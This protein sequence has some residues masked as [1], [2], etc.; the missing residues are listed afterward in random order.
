MKRLLASCAATIA[1]LLVPAAA[2]AQSGAV[3]R[4]NRAQQR[5]EIVDSQH[6]VRSYTTGARRAIRKLRAG[7]KVWFQ[8]RGGRITSLR[9]RGRARRIAFLAKVVSASNGKGLLL[10]L[11]DGSRLKLGTRRLGGRRGHRGRAHRSSVQIN[12]EGLDPGQV[13]LITETVDGA[14][15]VTI[16]IK[17]MPDASPTGDDQDVTGTITALAADG[18]TIQTA[19]GD[20][21]TF[22]ADPVLLEDFSVGDQVDV[23]Y[24]TDTAGDLVADDVEPLD[25]GGDS[26]DDLDAVGSVTAIAADS[27]TVQ[28]DGRGPMTFSADQELLDGVAVGDVVDVT[29]FQDT[30]GTLVADDIEP[31]DAGSGD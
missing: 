6:A 21:M 23:S 7:A 10:R 20:W 26:S 15:N 29:Y 8:A 14:G 30:D 24:Y 13:V 11:G 17:L 18:I 22:Q 19:G 4:V 28:V 9:V 2:S 25:A 31:V 3:L 16:T 1:L 27:I 5:V 12:L